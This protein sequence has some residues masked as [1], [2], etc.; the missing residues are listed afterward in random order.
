MK[1]DVRGRLWLLK[2]QVLKRNMLLI[3][4]R[5]NEKDKKINKYEEST[6]N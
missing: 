1:T 3:G 2:L 4:N 6:K 5:D